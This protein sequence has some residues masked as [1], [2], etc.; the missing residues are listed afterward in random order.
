M[1]NLLLILSIALLTIGCS[2]E[3]YSI[4]E[5]TMNTGILLID[6]TPVDGIV[7]AEFEN[8][9]LWREENYQYGKQHGLQRYWHKNGQL[10]HEWNFKD[11][12]GKISEKYWDEDGNLTKD[13][14]Y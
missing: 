3:R 8:G 6:G 4:D 12:K 11:G 5:V 13:K 7:F 1:K 2:P 9:Q 14:T 10:M